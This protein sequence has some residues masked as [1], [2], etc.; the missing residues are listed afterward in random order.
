[1]QVDEDVRLDGLL[2]ERGGHVAAD[3]APH[4][5]HAAEALGNGKQHARVR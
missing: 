5:V 4:V 3:G 1:V 2:C